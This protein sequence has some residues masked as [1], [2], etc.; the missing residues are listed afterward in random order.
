MTKKE[1]V[2][3]I[4]VGDK[5]FTFKKPIEKEIAETLQKE[6]NEAE[7]LE[8]EFKI[9]TTLGE[10]VELESVIFNKGK[11]E[12]TETDRTI[13][14]LQSENQLLKTRLDDVNSKF[15][16]LN[17]QLTEVSSKL[18]KKDAETPTPIPQAPPE[19]PVADATPVEPKPTEESSSDSKSAEVK[20]EKPDESSEESEG[21]D[22]KE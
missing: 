7:K 12:V 21:T 3:E 22:E 16:T 5:V 8:G 4:P 18:N 11:N 10:D 17:H 20:E 9:P 19:A 6:L 15:D 2:Q 14:S 1:L 13:N